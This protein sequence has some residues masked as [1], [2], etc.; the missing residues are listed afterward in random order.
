MAYNTKSLKRDQ[1]G[2]PIPQYFDTNTDDYL[3]LTQKQ[4]FEETRDLRGLSTDTKPTTGIP[5]YAT[6]LELDTGKLYYW[7]GS[8]WGV[9]L[10]E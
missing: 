2:N 6:F 9:F 8:V 3:P 7:T 10:G 4:L 1:N 5:L